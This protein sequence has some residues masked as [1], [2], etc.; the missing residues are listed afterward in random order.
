[1]LAYCRREIWLITARASKPLYVFV[2][3]FWTET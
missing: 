1:M 2:F 3:L